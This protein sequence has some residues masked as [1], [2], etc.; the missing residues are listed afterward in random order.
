MTV[1]LVELTVLVTAP[2]LWWGVDSLKP[3]DAR[4][5]SYVHKYLFYGCIKRGVI[6][7][8][9]QGKVNP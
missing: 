7:E 9:T 8:L 4:V 2:L 5:V 6:M 1:I 3:F